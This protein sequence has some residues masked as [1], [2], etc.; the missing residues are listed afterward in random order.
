MDMDSLDG[1]DGIVSIYSSLFDSLVV[2]ARLGGYINKRMKK[3]QKFRAEEE[4]IVGMVI[5]FHPDPTGMIVEFKTPEPTQWWE[6]I[7]RLSWD[8]L[9]TYHHKFKA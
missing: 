6:K 4:N 9:Y 1:I 7:G 2:E 3:K 5:E 8:K